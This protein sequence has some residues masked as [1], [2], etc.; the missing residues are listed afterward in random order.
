MKNSEKKI[1]TDKLK[2]G[3]LHTNLLSIKD[4]YEKINHGGCGT[5]SYYVS[6]LLDKYNIENEVVYIEETKTPENS[7]RCDVKFDHIL[8]KT[9]YVFIDS[10]GFYP[11]EWACLSDFW[12]NNLKI[13]P[14]PKLFEMLK[15]PRLWNKEFDEDKRNLLAED[16]LKIKLANEI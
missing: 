12:L 6:E 5:F 1:I 11:L 7:F 16:L 14:K 4:R 13:L 8:I 9:K 15:E 10:P 2:L 3:I